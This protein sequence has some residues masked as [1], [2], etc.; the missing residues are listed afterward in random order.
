MDSNAV[1]SLNQMSGD[2][3]RIE[4]DVSHLLRSVN[5]SSMLTSLNILL[6]HKDELEKMGIENIDEKIKGMTLKLQ[7]QK[8]L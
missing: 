2:I 7:K 3:A 8:Y 1:H 4:R 5:W 6:T